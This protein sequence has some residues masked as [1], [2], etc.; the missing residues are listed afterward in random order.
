M[1]RLPISA[2]AF[3][4][5]RA[6][7]RRFR[8]DLSG[9]LGGL[10]P[11]G[12]LPAFNRAELP[13]SGGSR[14]VGT[15]ILEGRFTRFGQT[16]AAEPG[17]VWST[18]LPSMRFARWLHGFGWLPDLLSLATPEAHA[19]ARD[20]VDGW[21][22]AYGRYHAFAWTPAIT[23]RRLEAWLAGWSPALGEGTDN[24]SDAA[25]ERR[26]AVARQARFL[27]RNLNRL[28]AGVDEVRAGVALAL[29][30]ARL[31]SESGERWREAGL[32]QLANALSLQV[33][34]DGGHV[35][36][37]PCATLDILGSLRALDRLMDARGLT[38][39]PTVARAMDR[40]APMLAFFS[41]TDGG[42]AG[43]HGGGEGE[44]GAVAAAVGDA[45]PFAFAHQSRY[46]RLSRGETVLVADVGAAP[47]RPYDT[48][49]HLSP[50]AFEMSTA[51]GRLIV[52][53]AWSPEQPDSWREV[54][55]AT[56]AHSALVVD[57]RSAGKLDESE[58]LAD[59]AGGHP[60]ARDASPVRA[61]RKE[62]E[63]GILVEGEHAGYRDGS[64][65]VHSRRLFLSE[66]GRDLRG[67]DALDLPVGETPVFTDAVPFAV[68]FHLAPEVVTRVGEDG[69]HVRIVRVADAGGGV[70][71]SAGEEW[72]FIVGADAGV[73]LSLEE[74]AYLG[75]GD[76]PVRTRQ[77][78]LSGAATPGTRARVRWAL[79]CALPLP[80][81][82]DP[83]AAGVDASLAD[84]D[85]DGQDA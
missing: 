83:E 55:R 17:A 84:A 25:A 62:N 35:S 15:A 85:P 45:R 69:R 28:P 11:P 77:I 70:V 5:T 52:N 44:P 12:D 82:P 68:R 38:L 80:D 7:L 65:L 8:T 49:A 72:V 29:L 53:C 71:T 43:F 20:L 32:G 9:G 36:R 64:G 74:S 37:A 46:H 16:F 6:R 30:G 58:L 24:G 2:R 54:V 59:L 51:G 3:A 48:G 67:E 31:P 34:P 63:L 41:H 47:P 21:V 76:C 81:A 1:A 26:R 60:V 19:R 57:G 23:A 50:L 18:P 73:T 40:S 10:V 22:A 13:A 56:A 14:A 66:D 78:V 75:A 33:L 79:R 42:L 39:P 27:R 4:G 61:D